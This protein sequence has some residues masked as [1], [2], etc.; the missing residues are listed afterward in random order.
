LYST[1]LGGSWADYGLAVAVDT[2]GNAYVTGYAGSVDFP[3]VNPLQATIASGQDAFVAK[4]NY[5]GS[6]LLYYTY[7]GGNLWD[8]GRGIAVDSDGNAY[9]TGE[10]YYS[11][12]FP[13]ASPLQST[14]GGLWDAYVA[15]LAPDGSDLVYSTFLGGSGWDWGNGITVDADGNAYVTGET[16]STDFP[17]RQSSANNTGRRADRL[18]RCFR[19]EIRS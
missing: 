10:T 2:D 13:T 16:S 1:Y 17:D 12:N 18:Y 7:L 14:H 4:L 11:T 6:A 19:G 9:V 5:T 8:T 3:T 15:K